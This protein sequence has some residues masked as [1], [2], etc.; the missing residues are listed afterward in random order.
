M[1]QCSGFESFEKRTVLNASPVGTYYRITATG[2]SQ[3]PQNGVK[4]KV[5]VSLL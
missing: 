3:R 4:E 1:T 5:S 2:W